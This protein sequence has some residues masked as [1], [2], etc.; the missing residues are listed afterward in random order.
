MINKLSANDRQRVADALTK[1]ATETRDIEQT[2]K[3][4]DKAY[5]IFAK[6][7]GDSPGLFK[8]A[9][10]VYNSCKSIHKLSAASDDTRGNS[11]AILNVQDMV[12]RLANDNKIALR[13]SANRPAVFTHCVKNSNGSLQKAASADAH[14]TAK[15]KTAAPEFSRGDYQQFVISDIAAIEDC[16]IKAANQLTNAEDKLEDAVSMFVAVMSTTPTTMRKDACSRLHAYYGKEFESMVDVFNERRPMQKMASEVYCNK[17]KGT[18]SLSEPDLVKAVDMVIAMRKKASEAKAAYEAVVT[19]CSETL[20][21]HIAFYKNLT[22]KADI[23]ETFGK[24]VVQAKAIGDISE[25][26]GDSKVD[27]SSV[28][29]KIYNTKLVNAIIGHSARRAL[30][31]AI[32]NP[33]I[34]S[35]PLPEIIPATNRAIARLPIQARKMPI[36]ANQS[37]FESLLIS[38]LAT[39]ATPSKADVQSIAELTKAFGGLKPAY[40]ETQA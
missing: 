18:P 1:C 21:D 5:S 24:A 29:R 6:E 22:K 17:Y 11:F 32:L 13:K 10:Q 34:S 3:L 25:L 36:T 33:T 35:Y 9:C 38:E 23:G 16:L 2:D 39:K 12:D 26:L 8:A 14:T 7:L 20:R 15:S 27:A 31:K 30:I 37:L 19:E 28:E 40:E 4:A